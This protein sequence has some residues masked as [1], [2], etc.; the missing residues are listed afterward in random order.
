MEERLEE[1]TSAEEI[2]SCVPCH[3]YEQRSTSR[4]QPPNPQTLYMDA[5]KA[6]S[7]SEAYE[8]TSVTRLSGVSLHRLGWRCGTIHKDTAEIDSEI[9]YVLAMQDC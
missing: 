4:Q 9:I 2:E 1:S 6:L 5:A 3:M 8:S 7:V